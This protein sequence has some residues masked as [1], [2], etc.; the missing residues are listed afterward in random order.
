[1]DEKTIVP[2]DMMKKTELMIYKRSEELSATMVKMLCK[3][4]VSAV[5]VLPDV[6]QSES[7]LQEILSKRAELMNS[8]D[9]RCAIPEGHPTFT[10]NFCLDLTSSVQVIILVTIEHLVIS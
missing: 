9:T 4:N 2:V 3:G 6:R 7:A 10:L 8:G 1:M 5:L